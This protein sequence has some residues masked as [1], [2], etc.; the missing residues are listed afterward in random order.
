MAR[1][2][3]PRLHASTRRELESV[4]QVDSSRGQAAL[5]LARRIETCE[6]AGS[7]V[8]ALVREWRATMDAAMS[9]G[10][11]V[12]D[13]VDELQARRRERRGA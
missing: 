9:A 8:A 7:A 1:A 6:D 5:L 13:P 2:V 11:S 4:G 3:P 10:T 12:A